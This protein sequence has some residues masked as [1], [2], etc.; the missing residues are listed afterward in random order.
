METLYIFQHMTEI[1]YTKHERWEKDL[2]K[3]NLSVKIFLTN[4]YGIFL[5]KRFSVGNFGF[6]FS[7]TLFLSF[8]FLFLFPKIEKL[9]TSQLIFTNVF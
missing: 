5:T 4:V 6:G 1:K 8:L 3:L 9:K 7:C 2:S